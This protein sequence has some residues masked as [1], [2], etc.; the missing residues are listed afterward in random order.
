MTDI[1]SGVLAL[2]MAAA[3]APAPAP[4]EKPLSV[5]LV[6]GA[7]VDASGWRGVYDRLTKD[8]YEVLVVQNPTITL[9]DDVAVTRRAIA[10]AKHPVILVGH[11]YGGSVITEA[12]N[13][14]KVRS[15]VYLAAFAPDVGESV[16]KLAEKPVPGEP[17]APLLPPRDGFLIVDPAKFPAAFAADMDAPT[18][19]F[20]AAA[21]VPWGLN[22]VGG[23]ITSA[24]WKSKPSYYLVTTEDHMVPPTAQRSMARRSG[25]TITEIRS[26]HAVMMSHPDEV[27][28]LI[29]AADGSRR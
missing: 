24:A 3:P 16:A 18:T 13:D 27:A 22:A 8:G 1:I 25:A 5:V 29:E 15:L 14:P 12:G 4:A 26:S 9:T 2:A 28:M 17:Q 23:T 20:M 11:S 10:R 21:Q 7:F 6:H 19:A